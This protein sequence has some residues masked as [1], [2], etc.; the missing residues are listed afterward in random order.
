[1]LEQEGNVIGFNVKRWGR[2][3]TEYGCIMEE[4]KGKPGTWHQNAPQG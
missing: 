2:T 3:R 4:I 1:M